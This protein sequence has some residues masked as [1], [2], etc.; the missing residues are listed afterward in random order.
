M[1]RKINRVK[2]NITFVMN[3]DPTIEKEVEPL[4][5]ALEFSATNLQETFEECIE[6]F[7]PSYYA[8]D[9][10]NME[11]LVEVTKESDTDLEQGEA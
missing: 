8:N 9:E 7:L 6:P 3:I 4:A 5:E 1:Q 10:Y 2:L 11:M